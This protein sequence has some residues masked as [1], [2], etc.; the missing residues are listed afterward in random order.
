[1]VSRIPNESPSLEITPPRASTRLEAEALVREVELKWYA[2]LKEQEQKHECHVEQIHEEYHTTMSQHAAEC[3]RK[4]NQ[5][6]REFKTLNEA[7]TAMKMRDVQRTVEIQSLEASV[8][9]YK[10][11]L[12][13]HE[14][15]KEMN[16]SS[17]WER[18]TCLATERRAREDLI[19]QY[20]QANAKLEESNKML[21]KEKIM[22]QAT[23][24]KVE[25]RALAAG[26][27]HRQAQEQALTLLDKNQ[28][29]VRQLKESKI[30]LDDMQIENTAVY[31]EYVA[32]KK[33]MN[34]TTV[35]EKQ[36]HVKV[37]ESH[38]SRSS[39]PQLSQRV[40]ELEVQLTESEKHR[41]KLHNE[42][43]ELKGNVRVYVRI[44]PFLPSDGP[45]ETQTQ[46][47]TYDVKGRDLSVV[48]PI[49]PTKR[50]RFDHIVRPFQGQE[51][52]FE[53]VIPFIQS[54]LDGYHV[55]LLGYGQS[56]SGKTYT[57][58]GSGT[59]PM[60][61]I[62]PRAGVWI[63]QSCRDLKE[64][65]WTY[66]VKA[67]MIEIYNETI[68]DLLLPH[69]NSRRDIRMNTQTWE[70]KGLTEV[71]ISMEHGECHLHDMMQK[72]M[73]R[74]TI[75]N[76]GMNEESSRSHTICTLHL[77]GKNVHQEQPR[78][79]G[80]VRFVDLA[81]SERVSRSQVS[82]VG[83]K[84]S[85]AI[86]L[87]LSSLTNVFMALKKKTPH[88]PYRN[89]KLTQVLQPALS[90]NGK[91]L[92]IVNVS[93]TTQ[94]VNETICSLRFAQQVKQCELGPAR[95]HLVLHDSEIPSRYM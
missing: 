58:I 25:S 5:N 61:G 60:Q 33:E 92:M 32:F 17:F 75:A 22:L 77:W 66:D 27:S 41:R 50:F 2:K 28:E 91:T 43:Q 10:Y 49:H 9:K 63:L 69:G 95:Q 6:D 34:T 1:M 53:Q 40:S 67:T 3:E 52:I 36:I 74:R 30:K 12:S 64:Q 59:G 31:A 76:T 83:L 82:D 42:I 79:C 48:H 44:R 89:S 81:G 18:S 80:S 35:P 11:L 55:C 29:L 93:P 90:G 16:A 73:S 65:G 4:A 14:R 24:D 86:N 72:A 8:E 15:E 62:L 13:A 21:M 19:I 23:V 39:E 46:A 84:Q 71:T 87:S 78:R 56:G 26:V 54:A 51:S 57:M 7:L 70:L 68:Q 47:I 88:V 20:E 38:P 37:S 94:S 45:Q 85:Q